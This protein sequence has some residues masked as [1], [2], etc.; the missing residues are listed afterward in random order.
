MKRNTKVNP[1]PIETN[2]KGYNFRS[3]LEARWAIFFD[4]TKF[5]WEYEKEGYDLGELGYYLPDFWLVQHECWVEIKGK[6]PIKTELEKIK[7]LHEI[8]G[9]PCILFYGMPTENNG[10]AYFYNGIDS[11][12]KTQYSDE[13]NL[14][15]KGEAL[16]IDMCFNSKK[17][18]W[19]LNSQFVHLE[20]FVNHV[21]RTHQYFDPN[22]ELLQ[23]GLLYARSARF[24]H[25]MQPHVEPFVY[26]EAKQLR[27]I[28]SQGLKIRGMHPTS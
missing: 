28:F 24:Q 5:K 25:W 13:V 15:S 4:A 16:E 27:R 6:Y 9:D 20:Y 23:H 8:T 10:F 26:D 7:K 12:L 3:R 2:Y 21:H 14:V 22:D 1:I 18:V 11:D 17:E 19:V